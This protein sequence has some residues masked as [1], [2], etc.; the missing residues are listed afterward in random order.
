MIHITVEGTEIY[1]KMDTKLTS[2]SVG[3]L[4]EF[5]FDKNWD[6][7]LKTAVFRVGNDCRS[8]YMG[9]ENICEFPW[10]LLTHD[11]VNQLIHIGVC[12]MRSE[13]IVFPTMYT[14]VGKLEEG[15]NPSADPSV[16][17]SPELV[18]QLIAMTEEAI[19]T[20][21]HQ[22]IIGEN[23]NW[24][25]WDIELQDYVDTGVLADGAGY[26]EE[27][28]AGR[29][30]ANGGEI[31]NDY[32]NNKAGS[33][34]F[35]ITS[36]DSASTTMTLDSTEGLNIGYVCSVN[37][38]SNWDFFGAVVSINGNSVVFDKWPKNITFNVGA[39]LWVPEHPEIGTRFIGAYSHSEG[40]N[41][42]A[43]HIAAHAE[44]GDNIAG[45]KYAHAEGKNNK[46]G[47]AAHA[48]GVNNEAS[49][50]YSHTEGGSN[51]S[52][53][54]SS[55]TEGY[56]NT[57]EGPMAHAEGKGNNAVGAYSHAEGENTQAIGSAAHAEGYSSVE[58][59][60]AHS[61]GY[62]TKA[63]AMYAHAEGKGAE[64]SG[65]AAHAEGEAT[66]ASGP[67]SH[68]EGKGCKATNTNTHA[69]GTGCRATGVASHAEGWGS[70]AS[71]EG[72]HA[73]NYSKASGK[74]T[75]SNGYGTEAG[76]DNQTVV[77]QYNDNKSDTM[78][79]VGNGSSGTKRSNA[80]EVYKDGSARV[81]G[82]LKI[83]RPVDTELA[84][85]SVVTKNDLDAALA[86]VGGGTWKQIADITTT[87]EVGAIN[88][89]VEDFAQ[90]SKC[91][92]FMMQMTL[93]K[94]GE[95]IALGSFY[96]K[97]K[98]NISASWLV[99]LYFTSS[100]ST[101]NA[102]EMSVNVHSII[103]GNT[104]FSVGA[105]GGT[106]ALRSTA[107]SVLGIANIGDIEYL[108]VHLTGENV[109]PIGTRC[110]FYGKVES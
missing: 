43:S 37:S 91:K 5:K 44:G 86:N 19:D 75:H 67:N 68:A 46:A 60:Y 80:F 22:P 63:K 110:R 29:K 28:L 57:A 16:E 51:K 26:A 53:G 82:D 56:G 38:G 33:R 18:E 2:G 104:Y 3:R 97:L 8:Y 105:H 106:S 6:G 78:F 59:D 66:V 108:T 42:I 72:S 83:L 94:T 25:V 81:Q 41:N 65:A 90:I 71:G 32:E 100:F 88:A 21:A 11:K 73:E 61:E 103:T 36:M 96:Y 84:D 77:G 95:S 79:E 101:S 99:Y 27:E 7:L 12:G 31:F 4:V 39:T 89:G 20:V 107:N 87:E 98:T 109:F 40:Y 9:E 1:G 30:Q 92:E 48:E 52:L 45:G 34:A 17:H 49:G 93:P 13:E 54:E 55:H 24:F 69:E 23:K 14:Y 10:E 58:G 15:A 50:L 74:Y 102:A 47:Y 85:N 35:T 62:N 64:A 76:Y 70:E